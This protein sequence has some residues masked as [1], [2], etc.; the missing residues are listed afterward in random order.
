MMEN[1]DLAGK[2]VCVHASLSAFS[3]R[4]SADAMV[5]ELLAMDCSVIAPAFTYFYE[6][7]AP[8]DD[9]P[10]HNGMTYEKREEQAQLFDPARND[11]SVR[12]IG[13]LSAT[14]LERPGRMRGRH[15]LNSFVAVGPLAETLTRGQTEEDVYAPFR[16]LIDNDGRLLLLGTQF[17]SLTFVH[18]AEQIAG[19]HLFIRWARDSQGRPM[20]VR[21]GSCSDGF[22]S[23]EPQ[24]D[25]MGIQRQHHNARIWS[26]PAR[27]TLDRLVE[28]LTHDP[29]LTHCGD[30]SCLRCADA[31]AGGP[32]E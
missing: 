5:D 22:S 28:L 26:L 12:D 11:L 10:I 24:L 21:V 4:L 27:A 9:H 32:D 20:R 1:L 8:D 13:H 17:T 15:P 2:P 31:I 6:I 30:E 29:Q 7:N 18:F 23:L 25:D 16:Q 3:P 19:R 14:L